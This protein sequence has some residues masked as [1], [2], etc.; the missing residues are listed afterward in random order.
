MDRYTSKVCINSNSLTIWNL[1][2][3]HCICCVWLF[4]GEH[5]LSAQYVP[6]RFGSVTFYI[7]SVSYSFSVCLCACVHPTD[8][9]SNHS[10]WCRGKI[11]YQRWKIPRNPYTNG[12][13]MCMDWNNP[14][15]GQRNVQREN[16]MIRS[17]DHCARISCDGQKDP[18]NGS[19]S[20]WYSD[21]PTRG[22]EQGRRYCT[23]L[24]QTMRIW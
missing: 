15:T 9:S 24:L 22:K 18:K 6:Y 11:L 16:I 13:E 20:C 7:A 3:T 2:L 4:F 1:E 14:T 19:F 5:V 17:S 8:P 23:E 10:V 12:Y 21:P